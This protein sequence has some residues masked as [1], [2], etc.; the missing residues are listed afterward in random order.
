[1]LD[2]CCGFLLIT[3]FPFFWILNS[4]FCYRII[5]ENPTMENYKVVIFE[6][7]MLRAIGKLTDVLHGV[8]YGE[9]FFRLRHLVYLQQQL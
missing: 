4:S 2:I 3:V 1:M 8:C 6:K 5:A 7:G 9:L